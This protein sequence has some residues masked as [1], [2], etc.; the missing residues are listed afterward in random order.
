MKDERSDGEL[1]ACFQRGD[2]NA[3]SELV[4]RHQ[5]A[6]LRHARSILGQSGGWEDVVQEVFLRLVQSPPSLP[7]AVRGRAGLERSHLLS[8]LHKVARNCCMD[9]LRAES[10]RKRRETEVAERDLARVETGTAGAA[11]TRE[12][13][14]FGL[15]KLPPDQKEVLVLRLLGDRSYREIAEITGRKIGTV[16]WLV[17]TGL[18]AL[19]QHLAPLLDGAPSRGLA[20][21]PARV[22][23]AGLG[24]ARGEMS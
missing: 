21:R 7:D 12:A 10:R 6:L 4:E 11:D 16:G 15:E 13:V 22:T 17:S 19:S 24:F 14:E 1:L 9:V 3:F 23:E 5:A 2:T 8:W 18:K 20:A